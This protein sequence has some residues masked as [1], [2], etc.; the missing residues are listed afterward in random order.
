M[1]WI[2]LSHA[3][4]TNVA[5]ERYQGACA[6]RDGAGYCWGAPSQREVK[7]VDGPADLV[8]LHRRGSAFAALDARGD[9]WVWHENDA[10]VRVGRKIEELSSETYALCLRDTKGTARCW[11]AW[12]KEDYSEGLGVPV[13]ERKGAIQVIADETTSCVRDAKGVWC[14]G[15][16]DEP[17][18]TLDGATHA[19]MDGREACLVSDTA[20]RCTDEYAAKHAESGARR[21][22]GYDTR[23]RCV[24]PVEGDTTCT[25]GNETF[26]LGRPDRVD[27]TGDLACGVYGD[28]I[29]CRGQAADE[30]AALE[31]FTRVETATDRIPAGAIEVMLPR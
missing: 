1:W 30:W 17:R 23:W 25:V 22:W 9:A 31:T 19:V 15:A 2:A 27:V 3:G 21:V 13:W 12:A 4:V 29:A 11:G 6:V 16:E 18:V 28:R 5:V 10:P 24:T 7:R 26:S 8:V 14:Q 20:I